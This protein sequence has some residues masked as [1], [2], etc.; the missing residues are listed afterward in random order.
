ME[1]QCGQTYHI[2]LTQLLNSSLNYRRHRERFKSSLVPFQGTKF[3][4][5]HFR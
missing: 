1:G 4:M 3:H 2:C 5:A